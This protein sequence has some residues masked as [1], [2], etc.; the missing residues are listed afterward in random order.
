MKANGLARLYDRLTPEERFRLVL[1]AMARGDHEEVRRLRESC[2]RKRYEMQDAAYADRV[3][4]SLTLAMAALAELRARLERLEAF[5]RMDTLAA[6]LLSLA[7]KAQARALEDGFRMGL[8][9]AGGEGEPPLLDL[10]GLRSAVAEQDRLLRAQAEEVRT[11]LA[12]EVRAAL[13]ALGRFSREEL[14][15]GPETV[16][17]AWCPGVL[18]ELERVPEA[19]PDPAE[20]EE[21][22]AAFVSLWQAKLG[23][24]A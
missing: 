10:E 5:E 3:A 12:A 1:M 2:P 4:A 18:P 21:L 13:E 8:R 6:E 24:A 14:G 20:V 15:L 9:A 11:R 19:E 17:G 22:R 23:A 16:L 7:T